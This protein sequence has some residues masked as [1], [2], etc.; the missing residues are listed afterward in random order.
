[1]IDPQTVDAPLANEAEYR[2]VH[3]IE[4]FVFLDAEPGKVVDVEEAPVVDV[5]RSDPPMSQPIGLGFEQAMQRAEAFGH[6]DRAVDERD[7]PLDR[8]AE[9]VRRSDRAGKLL[10]QEL[11]IG[12][13]SAAPFRDGLFPHEPQ[14]LTDGED[15]GRRR[16]LF[17]GRERPVENDRVAWRAKR[18]ALLEMA[19]AEA[20]FLRVEGEGE[21]AILERDAVAIAQEGHH[22]LVVA[23]SLSQSMSKACAWLESSPH[24]STDRHHSLSA[25]MPTWLGTISRMRS[26]PVLAQN[27]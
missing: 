9:S 5:A 4:D 23:P 20:S 19:D 3:V 27:V 6:A 10:F 7:G 16:D 25:P 2:F 1:M 22:E 8:L 24:S 11:G 15:I 13:K 26:K 18:K 17:Q 21:L 14:P 12:G